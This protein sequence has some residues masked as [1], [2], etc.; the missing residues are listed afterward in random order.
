MAKSFDVFFTFNGNCREA[1]NFYAK[2]FKSEVSDFMT[3]GQAP[4]TDGYTVPE[5]DK[6]RII[7]CCVPIYGCN[8]MLSDAPTDS[9]AIVGCNVSPTLGDDNPEEV[10]RI[11]NELKEG[12]EVAMDLAKTFWSD[13]YGMVTDKYGIVWQICQFG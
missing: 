10:R 6:E 2:V 3:Y 12:G 7:Y 1:A 9:P 4:P 11:F 13:L 8:V 5:A